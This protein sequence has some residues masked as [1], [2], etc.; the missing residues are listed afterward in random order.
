M[1]RSTLT[2]G[3]ANQL[4]A[5]R[6]GRCLSQTFINCKSPMLWQCA[7]GHVWSVAMN[8]IKYSG[9]WCPSCAAGKSERSVRW[10]FE[11]IFHGHVF[12]S[13]YPDFLKGMRGRRLQ[14]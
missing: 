5:S 7:K 14:L 9:S 4:A 2:L 10:I 13:C 8:H 6:G 11:G 1:G 12:P 3:E